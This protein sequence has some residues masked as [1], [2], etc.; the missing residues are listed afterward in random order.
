A[1][2][3][4]PWCHIVR[5]VHAWYQPLL[6]FIQFDIS[7]ALAKN[8]EYPELSL[9]RLPCKIRP[10]TGSPILV[11]HAITYT[12]K[13]EGMG[14]RRVRMCSVI[15]CVLIGLLAW[16]CEHEENPPLR[17]STPWLLRAF[18]L[19]RKLPKTGKFSLANH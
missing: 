15:T 2:V 18:G 11:I 5:E 10:S 3:P 9:P 17:L 4:C 6:Q 16:G 13:G 19:C 1:L 12:E 7:L 8:Q 14:A